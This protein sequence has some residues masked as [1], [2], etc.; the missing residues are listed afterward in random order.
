MKLMSFNCRV[1]AGPHKIS[2]L[3]R[4]VGLEHPDI[5]MLQETL[6]VGEVVKAKLQSWFPGWNFETLNVRG[7]YG[8]L[9]ISWNERTAKALNLWGMESV[10]GMNFLELDLDTSFTFFNI[11]GLYLN[12]I[13]FWDTLFNNTLLRGDL[14]ILGGDLNFSMGQGEVWGPHACADL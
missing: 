14:V 11:Y 4:V 7:C 5:L 1:L 12:R 13:P 10:L 2:A 9:E 3:K 8:G 6:C